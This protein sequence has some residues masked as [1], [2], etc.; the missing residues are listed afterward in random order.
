TRS[1]P[2]PEPQEKLRRSKTEPIIEEEAADLEDLI[3]TTAAPKHHEPIISNFVEQVKQ[4]KQKGIEIE[5]EEKI[6]EP[7]MAVTSETDQTYILPS[8]QQLNPPPEHDQSGEYSVIQTNAKK[9]EQTFLSFGV[10]AKVTQVHLGPAVTKYEV[11]PD[12]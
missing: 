1:K 4:E 6:S 10:K 2:K 7:I 8:M 5:V 12:T 9:L 11:M 3:I